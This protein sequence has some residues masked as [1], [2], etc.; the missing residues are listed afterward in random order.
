MGE[1][2]TY[3]GTYIG[4]ID[5][6][7]T[8]ITRALGG[9]AP[10]KGLLRKT[11]PRESLT[12]SRLERRCP[13]LTLKDPS[14]TT[15][16]AASDIRVPHQRRFSRQT[17][18]RTPSLKLPLAIHDLTVAYHRKPVLWDIE[19]NIPEGKLVAHRWTQWR[20]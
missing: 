9:D 6:N 11:L 2:G 17:L 7:V 4:M 13:P 15:P 12:N 20:R 19:L 16:L 5:H 18:R 1:T 10:E 14:S 3:E 8:T